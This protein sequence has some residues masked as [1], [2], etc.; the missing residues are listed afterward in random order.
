MCS[1]HFF[2]KRIRSKCTHITVGSIPSH[3]GQEVCAL[4]RCFW[5]R[6]LKPDT[7]FDVYYQYSVKISALQIKP[8]LIQN[9]NIGS[10]HPVGLSVAQRIETLREAIDAQFHLISIH[11]DQTIKHPEQKQCYV[12]MD[13]QLDWMK[14]VIW[15]I[16]QTI[17]FCKF[18]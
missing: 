1:E 10:L 4:G 17:S 5:P 7:N 13:G 16:E 2:K 14:L 15:I 3:L 11:L 9:E 6:K 8:L 12:Q 18:W